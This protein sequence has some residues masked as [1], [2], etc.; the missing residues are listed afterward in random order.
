LAILIKILPTFLVE[1]AYRS[2][3]FSIKF[4]NG[5]FKKKPHPLKV[6]WSLFKMLVNSSE[7]K[8]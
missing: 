1:K 7:K 8:C 6:R 5:I 4:G 3:Y 2:R